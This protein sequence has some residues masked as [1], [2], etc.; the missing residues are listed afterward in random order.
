MFDLQCVFCC[1]LI[2]SSELTTIV[3]MRGK[4]RNQS[5]SKKKFLVPTSEFTRTYYKYIIVVYC[6]YVLWLLECSHESGR[7]HATMFFSLSFSFRIILELFDMNDGLRK[8]YN[9][10]SSA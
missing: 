9:V 2:G 5:K 4:I 6:R 10:V 3:A 8:L 1:I 7:F